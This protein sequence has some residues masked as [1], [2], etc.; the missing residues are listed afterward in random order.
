MRVAALA[1]LVMLFLFVTLLVRQDWRPAQDRALLG[2]EDAEAGEDAC[3]AGS[4]GGA[5]SARASTRSP[6]SRSC[7]RSTR[8]SAPLPH[9]RHPQPLT[10]PRRSAASS[11]RCA[12][13]PPT[14]HLG[15]PLQLAARRG[16]RRGRR[17]QRLARLLITGEHNFKY[18]GRFQ[19]A[20][21]AKTAFVLVLDDD[22]IPGPRF[23]S[24]LLVAA[25]AQRPSL[26][27]PSAGCCRGRRCGREETAAPTSSSHPTALANT[28]G[29]YVPDGA[30]VHWSSGSSGSITSAA[31]FE[32]TGGL[33]CSARAAP[34]SPRRG[35]PL[36]AHAAEARRRAVAR[37]PVLFDDRSVWGDTEHALAYGRYST[38][39]GRSRCAIR[40]G[41]M[42]P[43]RRCAPLGSAATFADTLLALVDGP[44]H[45]AA[46]APLL[47]P[48]TASGSSPLMSFPAARGAV[49]GARTRGRAAAKAC[50]DWQSRARHAIG[51]MP[52]APAAAAAAKDALVT[53]AAHL[54]Y[55][56]RRAAAAAALAVVDG[57]T[58]AGRGL[59]R[60]RRNGEVAAPRL[61][62]SLG[63][64]S[65][66]PRAPPRSCPTAR[67]PHISLLA[68]AA[69]LPPLRSRGWVGCRSTHC[70]GGTPRRSR[71]R[72]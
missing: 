36:V 32:R 20:L 65:A 63:D 11:T 33:G 39:G 25:P 18:F 27:A 5:S 4:S 1:V 52:D 61:L 28:G 56:R 45:A 31:W 13:T 51:R 62:L 60:P 59:G 67:A 3:R 26:S 71:S 50:A 8:N 15:L 58:P 19:L 55:R 64:D 54:R 34:T 66:P 57:G 70:C 44:D 53:V 69:A 29:L 37:L 30:A 46:L 43:R 35:L 14:P 23:L 24:V 49:R 47:R 17:R 7:S 42:P 41:G 2:G 10:A 21:A 38:G 72:C 16:H 22:M 9:R 68:E 48:L 40:C 6:P 12:Q